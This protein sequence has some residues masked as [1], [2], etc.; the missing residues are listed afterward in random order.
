MNQPKQHVHNG[1][2]VPKVRIESD[3]TP[4]GTKVTVNGEPLAGVTDVRWRVNANSGLATAE[5]TILGVHVDVAGQLL[6]GRI[7]E[8]NPD[9]ST[10]EPS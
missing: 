1:P 4:L 5:L 7:R 9:G 6:G 10:K 3:G 8:L 2:D